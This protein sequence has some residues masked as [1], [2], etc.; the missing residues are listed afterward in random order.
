MFKKCLSI[1]TNGRLVID[2]EWVDPKNL[3]DALSIYKD[4]YYK[5]IL[6]AI[7]KHCQSESLTFDDKL[8]KLLKQV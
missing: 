5:Y 7:I 1:D 4:D 2:H 3:I 8:N 6:S